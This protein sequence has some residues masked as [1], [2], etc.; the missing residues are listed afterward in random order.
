[1]GGDLWKRWVKSGF[2]GGV[3]RFGLMGFILGRKEERGIGK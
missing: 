1:M 3:D 2:G